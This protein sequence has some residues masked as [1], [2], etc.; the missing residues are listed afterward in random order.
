MRKA[1]LG[2]FFP[3]SKIYKVKRNGIFGIT[4]QLGL[5]KFIGISA[6]SER[7]VVRLSFILPTLIF[8]KQYSLNSK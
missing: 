4:N 5:I 8:L 3:K 2:K 7:V 6:T 1:N